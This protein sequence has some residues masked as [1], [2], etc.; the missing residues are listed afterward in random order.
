VVRSLSK[1]FGLAGLRVGYALSNPETIEMMEKARLPFNLSS[2]AQR[3]AVKAL[4]EREWFDK[5]REEILK[6]REAVAGALNRIEGL[7][8]LGSEANFL[9][10][11]L[12]SGVNMERFIAGLHR[13][14]VIVRDVTGLHGLKNRYI[15]V[16]IGK[17]EENRRLISAIQ[18][19][20]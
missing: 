18:D 13:E 11:R 9:L 3:A 5:I 1:F 19:C 20:L 4:E 7:E 10:V 12:P 8:A 6:E 2:I 17:K 15:R 14:G 16:T